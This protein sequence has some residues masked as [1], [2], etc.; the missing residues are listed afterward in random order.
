M[1]ILGI[2]DSHESH[3]CILKSGKILAASAEERFS[4]VKTDCGYPK[5]AI[6]KVIEQSGINKNDIDMVVF[7][8]AKAG[9]FHTLMKP[10]ANFSVE[11]WIHQNE[12]YWKLKF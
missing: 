9:L 6:E 4:R 5:N 2:S 12:H 8:G 11:D 7:A 1:I 3:A 10:V